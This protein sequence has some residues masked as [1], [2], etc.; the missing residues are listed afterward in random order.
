MRDRI[1]IVVV[2]SPS[3]PE[4][5]LREQLFV[6]ASLSGDNEWAAPAERNGKV[7]LPAGLKT[8]VKPNFSH[9]A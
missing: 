8:G 7:S 6:L 2:L 9:R 3:T 5:F 4:F 1:L